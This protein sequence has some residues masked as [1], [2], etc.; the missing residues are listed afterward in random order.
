M[1]TLVILPLVLMSLMSSPSWGLTMDDTSHSHTEWRFMVIKTIFT[2]ILMFFI[3]IGIS[4]GSV[5][6]TKPW[7]LHCDSSYKDVRATLLL[8][9][10]EEYPTIGSKATFDDTTEWPDFLQSQGYPKTLYVTEIYDDSFFG[11]LL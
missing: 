8:F 1:R 6:S 3:S 7:A 11:F 9:G 5:S 10:D 4:S 2:S